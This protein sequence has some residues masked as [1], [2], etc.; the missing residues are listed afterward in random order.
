MTNEHN[1]STHKHA[2]S[3]RQHFAETQGC[4]LAYTV[5]GCSLGVGEVVEQRFQI[6]IDMLHF[7]DRLLGKTKCASMYRGRP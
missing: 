1:S 2:A 6:I 5:A 3:L 7:V 4:V